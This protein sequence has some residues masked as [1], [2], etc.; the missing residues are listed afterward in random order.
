MWNVECISIVYLFAPQLSY[1]FK[2]AFVGPNS[3]VESTMDALET[4]LAN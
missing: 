2:T 1:Q 4:D 3:N